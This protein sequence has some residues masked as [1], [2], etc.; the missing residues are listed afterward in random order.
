MA[1]QPYAARAGAAL[2]LSLAEAGRRLADIHHLV[3]HAEDGVNM[4]EIRN[5]SHPRNGRPVSVPEAVK[6]FRL[7][8]TRSEVLPSSFARTTHPHPTTTPTG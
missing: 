3:V 4:V 2:E 1:V 8:A 7:A 5:L 6:N